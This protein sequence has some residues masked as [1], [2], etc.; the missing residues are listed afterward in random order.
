M[1][2]CWPRGRGPTIVEVDNEGPAAQARNQVIEN[3]MAVL[4]QHGSRATHARRLILEVL[5]QPGHHRA[6]EIAATVREQAPD[7]HL[8]TIYRNLEELERLRI[9]DRTYVS[10]GPATYN[11]A[12]AAHGHLACES[13]GSIADL[14]GEAFQALSETAMALHGFTISPSHFAIPGRCARCQ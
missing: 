10:H 7:V 12:S 1:R 14:P 9:V 11:L 3:V 2:I 8:T 5:L 13:C 6:E 4:R